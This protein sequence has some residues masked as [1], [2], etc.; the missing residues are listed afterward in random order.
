M[1]VLRHMRPARNSVVCCPRPLDPTSHFERPVL[2]KQWPR[3]SSTRG[4]TIL[5]REQLHLSSSIY[6]DFEARYRGNRL[7]VRVGRYYVEPTRGTAPRE[8]FDGALV[9]LSGC[10]RC[11]TRKPFRGHIRQ[12]PKAINEEHSGILQW[13]RLLLV[14]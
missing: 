13:S 7:S 1:V 4:T 12:S 10:Q 3:R 9:C 11:G 6:D 2:A 14:A 8:K 5:H